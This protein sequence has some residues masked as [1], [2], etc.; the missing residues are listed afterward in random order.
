MSKSIWVLLKLGANIPT[1]IY[2]RPRSYATNKKHRHF[3]K[4][5]PQIT[6][7]I[8]MR[9]RNG[10]CTLLTF[11]LWTAFFC[12]SAA[13]WSDDSHFYV[14]WSAM[15]NKLGE[16]KTPTKKKLICSIACPTMFNRNIFYVYNID[17]LETSVCF[18]PP[19]DSKTSRTFQEVWFLAQFDQVFFPQKKQPTIWCCGRLPRIVS[20][21]CCSEG[22]CSQEPRASGS[23]W[24]PKKEDPVDSPWQNMAKPKAK[25]P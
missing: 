9:E 21:W 12:N 23:N 20:L 15:V 16:R 17:L 4:S 1:D 24:S 5:L 22:E 18:S 3:W 19:H 6:W 14:F 13:L 7:G 8:T 11:A 25:Q 10:S 2:W